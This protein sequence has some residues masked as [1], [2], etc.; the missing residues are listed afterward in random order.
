MEIKEEFEMGDQGKTPGNRNM[1]AIVLSLIGIILVI[2]GV[3]IVSIHGNPLRGSGLGTA[4][5]VIGIIML[6]IAAMRFFSKSKNT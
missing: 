2:I 1:R 6:A 4:A 3:A 5:I